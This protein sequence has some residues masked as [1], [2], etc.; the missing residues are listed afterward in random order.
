M[1]GIV[2]TIQLINTGENGHSSMGDTL[3]SQTSVLNLYLYID[4]H[5]HTHTHLHVNSVDHKLVS[6]SN[7][8]PFQISF[9]SVPTLPKA[10]PPPLCLM[11][12]LPIVI[13]YSDRSSNYLRLSNR[14]TEQNVSI[15][16]HYHCHN[17]RCTRT[18]SKL[19]DKHA[20]DIHYMHPTVQLQNHNHD[21]KFTI[22]YF[23]FGQ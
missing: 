6:T 7:F 19:Y 17:Y 21:L 16:T 14:S 11:G 15:V 10:S 4:T 20:A 23:Q 2:L 3:L 1:N 12:Q 8:C 13:A 5:T 9:F 22:N 18:A